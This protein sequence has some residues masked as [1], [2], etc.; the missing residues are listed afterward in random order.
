MYV[1]NEFYSS[2]LFHFVSIKIC[3]PNWDIYANCC[4]CF[5]PFI[6]INPGVVKRR[7]WFF[8]RF[9]YKLGTGN[10]SLFLCKSWMLIGQ[11]IKSCEK[12]RCKKGRRRAY[13]HFKITSWILKYL[14]IKHS[15]SLR[16]VPLRLFNQ[17]FYFPFI[18]FHNKLLLPPYFSHYFSFAFLFQ[19]VLWSS[20]WKHLFR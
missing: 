19:V 11:I 6:T 8:D 13:R 15:S 12:C 2:E 3:W 5:L 20:K 17:H 18:I 9:F 14:F 7:N 1:R 4:F 10:A 16:F